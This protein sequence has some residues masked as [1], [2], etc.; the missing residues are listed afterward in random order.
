MLL[1]FSPSSQQW[2][3]VTLVAAFVAETDDELTVSPGDA[4]VIQAEVDG[5]YQVT[6]VADGARGLIPAS[7]ASPA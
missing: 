1:A 7:Y 2:G 5:W 3:N 4:I 6:R